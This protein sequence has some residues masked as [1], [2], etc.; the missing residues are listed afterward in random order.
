MTKT[1]FEMIELTH[2]SNIDKAIPILTLPI[3]VFKILQQINVTISRL[4]VHVPLEA[5]D[6]PLLQSRSDMQLLL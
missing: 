6:Y 2:C 3:F 4:F 5:R 1:T